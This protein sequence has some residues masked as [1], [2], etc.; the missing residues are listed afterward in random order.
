MKKVI[1]D[2]DPGH[3]DAFGIMLAAKHLDLLGVTTVGGNGYLHNVTRNALVVLEQV[4]R[5]DVHRIPAASESLTLP[6]SRKVLR[7]NGVPYVI[8][9][10]G[11]SYSSLAAAYGLT[12]RQILR[13]NDLAYGQ[14]LEPDTIVYLARKKPQAE[15][16]WPSFR[17]HA[18]SRRSS[19]A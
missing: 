4:G 10:E 1:L 6:M 11:D 2:C 9:I 19:S 18:L 12:P 16:G 8:S 15:I 14:E 7:R 17:F 5:T 3:D 13:Y